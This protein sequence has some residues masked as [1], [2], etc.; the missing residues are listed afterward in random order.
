MPPRRPKN[1]REMN[2][3]VED[4][5]RMYLSGQTPYKSIEVVVS[6]LEKRDPRKKAWTRQRLSY[7]LKRVKDLMLRVSET[8]METPPRPGEKRPAEGSPSQQNITD[9]SDAEPPAAI[10][11]AAGRPVGTTKAASRLNK[12]INAQLLDSATREWEKVSSTATVSEKQKGLLEELTRLKAAKYRELFPDV[13]I[14]PP[15]AGTIRSRVSRHKK[16]PRRA[17]L[18]TGG[19]GGGPPPLLA[20]VEPLL[21]AWIQESAAVNIYRCLS[22]ICQKTASLIIDTAAGEKFA[23]H[24]A[25]VISTPDICVSR[26]PFTYLNH[27]PAQS[28]IKTDTW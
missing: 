10:A 21:V 18:E 7:Q 25:L 24:S 27:S 12:R 13:K 4:V 1:A 26:F 14:D 2:I 19:R 15:V 23:Y 5:L 17:S 11:R 22:K 9:G 16:N 8:R 28:T 6:T 20:A 3:F